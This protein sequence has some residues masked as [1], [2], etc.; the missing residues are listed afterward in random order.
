VVR[1]SAAKGEQFRVIPEALK[2]D[3]TERFS[4]EVNAVTMVW[5]LRSHIRISL[6]RRD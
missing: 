1:G 2:A 4:D 3:R 5:A 6:F